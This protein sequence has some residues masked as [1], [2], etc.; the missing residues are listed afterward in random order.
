MPGQCARGRTWDQAKRLC[1]RKPMDAAEKQVSDIKALACPA[2]SRAR[3]QP[4]RRVTLLRAAS[5]LAE[6]ERHRREDRLVPVR[7]AVLPWH[8]RAWPPKGRSTST[9]AACVMKRSGSMSFWGVV[10]ATRA[11]GRCANQRPS[12][13]QRPQPTCMRRGHARGLDFNRR[14]IPRFSTRCGL[15]GPCKLTWLVVR[16]SRV[17]YCLQAQQRRASSRAER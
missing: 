1:C 2:A 8:C 7:Q 6:V 12:R 5:R 11:N 10:R 13:A 16:R 9:T 17:A 4:T 3:R 14:G 15:A